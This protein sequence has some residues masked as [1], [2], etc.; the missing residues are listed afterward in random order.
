MVNGT[1]PSQMIEVGVDGWGYARHTFEE[2]QGLRKTIPRWAVADAPLHFFKY[3]DEQT[4][5]AIRL[6]NAIERHGLDADRRDWA[7]IA[8]PQF[9]GREQEQRRF[10]AS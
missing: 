1:Q 10:T 4:I 9:L 6:D 5:V 8:A 2:V 3:S 7:V